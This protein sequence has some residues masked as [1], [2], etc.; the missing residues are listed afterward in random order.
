VDFVADEMESAMEVDPDPSDP[1]GIPSMAAGDQNWTC[2]RADNYFKNFNTNDENSE[3]LRAYF[4]KF[5]KLELV[6]DLDKPTT[7]THT[8][9]QKNLYRSDICKR[10]SNNFEAICF[11]LHSVFNKCMLQMN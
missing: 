9:T 6:N 8:H 7:H 1:F 10:Y 2:T 11:L 5:F 4:Q 3:L